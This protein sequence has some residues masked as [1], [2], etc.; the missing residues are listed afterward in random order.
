MIY[1]VCF[2]NQGFNV[3][4]IKYAGYYDNIDMALERLK[5]IIPKYTNYNEYIVKGYG[6]MA[7][8]EEIPFGNRDP[9]IE[10]DKK[11]KIN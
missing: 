10:Y 9:A 2:Y 5:E 7:W 1:R 6:R 8:I 11:I 3:N 4:G